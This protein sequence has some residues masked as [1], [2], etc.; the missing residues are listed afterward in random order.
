MRFV[1]V[2]EAPADYDVLTLTIAHPSLCTEGLTIS[3][4]R[5]ILEVG[6]RR[7]RLRPRQ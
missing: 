6:R 7:E 5:G 2:S 4:G 3:P 1:V